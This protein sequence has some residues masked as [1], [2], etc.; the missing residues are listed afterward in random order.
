MAR[1][2]MPAIDVFVSATVVANLVVLSPSSRM[3]PARRVASLVAAV[4]SPVNC[5][6]GASVHAFATAPVSTAPAAS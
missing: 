3:L 5:W 2:T 1:S 6:P 4:A